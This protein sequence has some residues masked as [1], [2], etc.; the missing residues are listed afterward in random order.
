MENGLFSQA[1]LA[2]SDTGP[3]R[4]LDAAVLFQTDCYVPIQSDFSMSEFLSLASRGSVVGSY[5]L[6]ALL[7]KYL[8]EEYLLAA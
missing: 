7:A 5:H 3:K 4:R 6:V 2:W 1:K 8:L